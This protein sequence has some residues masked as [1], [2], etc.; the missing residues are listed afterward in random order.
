MLL[1]TVSSLGIIPIRQKPYLMETVQ[2]ANG[3]ALLRPFSV[4]TITSYYLLLDLNQTYDI[5]SNLS[6]TFNSRVPASRVS[7][8]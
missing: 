8:P 4:S 1:R 5:L 6:K 3:V 2:V 7:W